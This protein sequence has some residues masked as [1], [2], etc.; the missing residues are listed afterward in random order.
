MAVG[1]RTDTGILS[2]DNAEKGD[3]PLEMLTTA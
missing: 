3:Q 1:T 2:A